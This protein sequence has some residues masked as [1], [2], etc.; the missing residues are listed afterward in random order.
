MRIGIIGAGNVGGTLG[1]LWAG[2]GHRVIFGVRDPQSEKVHAL[3]SWIGPN[4]RAGT[5]GDAAQSGEVVVLAVGWA[6][7]SEVLAQTGDIAGKVLIDCTNRLAPSQPGSAPSAA[8][9]VARLAPGARVV[10]AFN[11]LGAE[12]LMDLRFDSQV[13]STFICG[14][15]PE[16]K[17]VVK[18]LG[19]DLGFDVVDAGP[20]SAAEMIESLARL[21]I[22]LSRSM[23]RDIAFKLLRR[24]R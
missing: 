14:D 12:N 23:G 5:I 18:R 15:D 20:L 10:K 8:E 16:A 4:A 11:T 2:A 21:W 24:R 6:A 1:K 22:H 7:L 19:E 9:E 3:L 17:A 13:A